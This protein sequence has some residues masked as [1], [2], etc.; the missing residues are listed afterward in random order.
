MTEIDAKIDAL[1]PAWLTLPDVAERL[2]VDVTRVRQLVKEGQLI[3]VRRG[4]NRV[5][6][7]PEEFIGDGKVVKGLV[8]TLTLLKDDGFSDEEM[9]EWLFTPDPSLPG[10]PAQALSENRGTEVKRRAQALAV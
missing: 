9:L 2:R 6:Q 4:E 10:T 8:G 1:V 3:A 7:V 5:L